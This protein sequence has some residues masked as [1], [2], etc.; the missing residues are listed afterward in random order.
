MFVLEDK[1]VK[2]IDET[3]VPFGKANTL[4]G[5]ISKDMLVRW[6]DRGIKVPGRHLPVTLE[7]VK[8]GKRYYTTKEAFTRFIVATNQ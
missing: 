8:I 1:A 5:N 2:L 7:C 3:L 4:P 6:R